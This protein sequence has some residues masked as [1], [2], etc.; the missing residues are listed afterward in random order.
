MKFLLWHEFLHVHLSQLHTPTF[1][2]LERKWPN[3]V[4]ADRQ[5]DT[6]NEKFGIQYW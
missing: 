6:L 4:E 5:L 1:R 3:M 2:E